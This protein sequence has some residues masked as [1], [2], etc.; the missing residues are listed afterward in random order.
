M[1]IT[2]LS[3]FVEVMRRGSF[4]AVAKD[5]NVDPSSISRLIASLEE[6]LGIRLFQRSTRQLTENRRR[7]R[8]L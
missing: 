2:T 6:E 5:R 8:L 4:A 3:I 1:D 7:P